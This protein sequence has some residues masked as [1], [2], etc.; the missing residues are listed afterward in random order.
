MLRVVGSLTTT[1]LVSSIVPASKEQEKQKHI[2]DYNR[3][4]IDIGTVY[5]PKNSG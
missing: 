3:L 2:L 5:Y 4:Y 1:H